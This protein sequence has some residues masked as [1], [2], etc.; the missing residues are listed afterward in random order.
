MRSPSLK[1]FPKLPDVIICLAVQLTAFILTAVLEKLEAWFIPDNWRPSSCFH[2]YSSI[3]LYGNFHNPRNI[4]LKFCCVCSCHARQHLVLRCFFHCTRSSLWG[5]SVRVFK[6]LGT[7][8]EVTSLQNVYAPHISNVTCKVHQSVKLSSVRR[9]TTIPREGIGK[10]K[11]RFLTFCET[12]SYCFQ[13]IQVRSLA[14]EVHWKYQ[15]TRQNKFITFAHAFRL[16]DLPTTAPR[17]TEIIPK[18]LWSEASSIPA[19]P[20]S[21][22]THAFHSSN[23]PFRQADS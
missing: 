19:A 8:F 2:Q 10:L 11:P 20:L 1:K 4:S 6:K 21:R 16:Q 7:P 23:L 22:K 18:R 15:H 17:N 3:P 13:S 5:Y 12:H 9:N 14:G